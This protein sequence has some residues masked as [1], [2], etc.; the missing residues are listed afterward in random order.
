MIFSSLTFMY[1][2]LP[3]LLLAFFIP[4]SDSARRAVLILFSL[5]FYAWGEPV[6]VFLMIFTVAFNFVFGLLIDSYGL[7]A[8]D[9]LKRKLWLITA[10]AVNLGILSVYKYTGFLA[11]TINVV[12]G[13]SL[14]SPNLTM[15]IGI[16]FFTFQAMSY[17]ADVYR[18]D[19]AVQ[20]SFGRLL[21]YVSLF[22][23]LIAG[24]IVR[25]K[26]IA[27][28][29]DNMKVRPYDLNDGIFRFSVGLSKKILI[30]DSCAAAVSSLY[31]MSEVTLIGRW[32]GALFYAMQIY[33]DF[34]GYSDMAI[35]LGRMFGFKFLE[36]FDHPY[37]SSSATEFWRRWHM[38]LGSFF[39]DYVYIPLGGN[40]RHHIRNILVVWFLTGLWHGAS[41]N[42]VLWG[43]F[44]GVLLIFEKK[45]FLSFLERLPRAASACVSRVYFIF[46]TLFGFA[47]FYFESDTFRSLGYLF[48]IGIDSVS[49]IFTTSVIF[50]NLVLLAAAIILAYPVVPSIRRFAERRLGVSYVARRY[51]TSAA[52][53]VLIA[54]ST[55]RMVGNTY[56]PFI[57]WN[58]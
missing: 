51:F 30:A 12:L 57:Y 34:S 23:Q 21:L 17:V 10:V 37:A 9:R 22:P 41:W 6:Y 31:G 50:D 56:S 19:T 35:G 7:D 36:N 43:L 25:Y 14:P 42:F 44:Y 27:D 16:S 48:G 26:D 55:V 54:V 38:S 46:I 24:P 58:F 8:R 13:T 4:K 45:F 39:R 28:Q 52:T 2:F 20:R 3:A 15:P 40:R 53:L 5:L 47:L 18:R 11:D 1:I 33:Y 49:S 32:A 29:L